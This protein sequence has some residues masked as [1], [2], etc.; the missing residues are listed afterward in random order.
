MRDF[1]FV[2]PNILMNI[3]IIILMF[4]SYFYISQ[5]VAFYLRCCNGAWWWWI[6]Y[7]IDLGP[8]NYELLIKLSWILIFYFRN[9]NRM[10]SFVDIQYCKYHE[11]WLC[12]RWLNFTN[13]FEWRVLEPIKYWENFSFLD[14]HCN[15]K[16]SS[17]KENLALKEI[18][19]KFCKEK[20]LLLVD[21]LTYFMVFNISSWKWKKNLEFML[22]P[23]VVQSG[24]L[25]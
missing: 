19:C 24:Y 25:I 22:I 8:C 14:E 2:E 1:Y 12:I 10:L 7:I 6:G 21:N 23:G 18:N 9:Q 15:F 13:F 17:W 20:N 11:Q 16:R 5:P 3:F 4:Q